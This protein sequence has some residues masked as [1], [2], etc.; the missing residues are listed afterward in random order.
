MSFQCVWTEF[1]GE[2]K[3]LLQIFLDLC[4]IIHFF[5]NLKSI[6]PTGV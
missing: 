5:L 4:H 1:L 6:Y 2:T 3:F